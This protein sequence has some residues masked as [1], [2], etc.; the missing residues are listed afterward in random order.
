MHLKITTTK[1]QN[2]HRHSFNAFKRHFTILI[3][4]LAIRERNKKRKKP[5]ESFT[6]IVNMNE[7]SQNACPPSREPPLFGCARGGRYALTRFF[8]SSQ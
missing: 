2:T 7:I 3:R 5:S 8:P 4:K 1:T 6:T